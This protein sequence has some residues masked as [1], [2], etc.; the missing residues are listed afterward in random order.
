MSEYIKLCNGGAVKLFKI[1]D[2][3]HEK[4]RRKE[5]IEEKKWNIIDRSTK[6]VFCSFDNEAAS[7]DFFYSEVEINFIWHNLRSNVYIEDG[8]TFQNLVDFIKSNEQLLPFVEMNCP[9][10]YVQHPEWVG[11][12]FVQPMAFISDYHSDLSFSYSIS[13]N[14]GESG[15]VLVPLCWL[16]NGVEKIHESKYYYSFLDVIFAF[17]G[18]LETEVVITKNGLT[19][20][21]D[22]PVKA[23][24]NLTANCWINEDITLGD[25]FK[26]VE[27]EE[28]CCLFIRAY[29]WCNDIEEFHKSAKIPLVKKDEFTEKLWHL[30]IYRC[31]DNYCNTFDLMPNFHGI[32]ELDE[33]TRKYYDEHP[34]ETPLLSVNYGIELSPTNELVDLPVMANREVKITIDN[35]GNRSKVGTQKVVNCKYTL[36]DILDAIYWEIS[37]FGGPKEST[38]MRE[39]LC[40]QVTD[41]KNELYEG[42]KFETVEEMFKALED[43]DDN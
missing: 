42:Q 12:L 10:F 38:E 5:M 11:Q 43:E 1:D 7:E 23:F 16:Y 34:L 2:D 36:L 20:V 22:A 28:L 26:I 9:D 25:I 14:S 13:N 29:S 40:Q 33:D 27:N 15:I 24:E 30:D 21:T 8:F 18:K 17:F 37:F 4:Y 6:E 41:I 19:D 32:G 3:K 31:M 39:E 35:K